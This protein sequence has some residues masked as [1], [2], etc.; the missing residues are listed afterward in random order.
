MSKNVYEMDTDRIIEALENGQIPWAWEKPWGGTFDRA[1]NRVSKRPYSLLNQLLLKHKYGEYA[2]LKQWNELGGKIRKGEKAEFVV[3]WKINE[4]TEKNADGEDVKR[5]VPILR[6]YNVFHV[7]QVEGIDPLERPTREHE[8]IAEAEKVLRDYIN[9][10]GILFEECI[11]DE[12]YYSPSRDLVH[13]PS[14]QQYQRI[15]EFWSTTYHELL[16]STGHS[17]RLARLDGSANSH[18]GSE[19]YSKEELVA[20][21]GS[22][23]ILNMLGIETTHSFKNS[24][25]YIQNWLQVLRNDSHFI[26]SASARAEKAVEYI[27]HGKQTADANTQTAV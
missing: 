5:V 19:S 20:E 27:M 10:E 18:F 12:A 7:S 3:F 22:A 24:S 17:S 9:R 11:T 16:H 13:V 21:I 23:M 25:A 14:R 6:Y 15:E 8:P 1:Y 2:T 4:Y 26:V